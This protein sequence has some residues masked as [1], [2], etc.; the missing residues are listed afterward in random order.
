M[1]SLSF[2]STAGAGDSSISFWWRRWTEQSRS[3]RWM[4]L[5]CSSASTCT[6][7]AGVGEVALDV[8]GRVVE[9]LLAL[10]GGALE[11]LLEL[12]LLERDP[13]PLAAAAPGRLDRD[14]I[15]DRLVD[16]LP[17]V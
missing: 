9:E 17:G 11:G 4:T 16:D 13:E 12:F 8:D 10:A 1:R 5:P 14:R 7:V 3:P 2:S 15:A 6:Y